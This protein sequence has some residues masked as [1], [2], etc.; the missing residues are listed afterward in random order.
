M[1]SNRD[2][3]AAYARRFAK[4][5]ASLPGADLPWLSELRADAMEHFRAAG[6]PTRKVEA[7][8]YTNLA[9]LNKTLFD[10]A[11]RKGN[12]VGR[13][14]FARF[15]LD[16]QPCHLLVF[17]GGRYRPDYSE[18]GKLPDG[19][20]VTS[21]ADALEATPE[22]LEAHLGKAHAL[23]GQALLAFNTAFMTDGAVVSL[24]AGV[25]LDAPI[26][27]LFVADPHE[28]PV[29]YPVRNLILADARSSVTVLETY[30]G[31]DPEHYWTNA[32]TQVVAGEGA[33]V[34]HYKLQREGGDAIHLATTSADL[35][36]GSA[37]SSFVLSLGGRLSR[38]EI[39]AVLDGGGIDCRLSGAYLARGRQHVDHSTWIDHAKPGSTSREVYKGV[40]DEAAHGV[41]QGKITVRA[42][43]NETDA[44][45][46]N[47]NLLLSESA[48]INTK[49]ELEIYADDVK[50]SHGATA[51]ELDGDA[52]FYLR[53]RGLDEESARRLLVEAFLADVVDGVEMA[54]LRSHLQRIVS[55]WMPQGQG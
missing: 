18:P 27:L 35:G 48:E 50:C 15:L 5:K 3:V 43:A 7:F 31:P 34:R 39:T 42:N 17:A 37:Y 26:Q 38:N 45:Q 8:K 41:F 46:L 29:A 47:Q 14:A 16:E 40:L 10:P 2:T 22:L 33:E 9:P 36:E 30:V 4:L 20:T 23:D 6:F 55:A 25:A 44:H 21:V 12:G 53:S 11:P 13:D 24:A 54:A 52:V 19:V 51:G 1:T 32:V 49:P 28:A